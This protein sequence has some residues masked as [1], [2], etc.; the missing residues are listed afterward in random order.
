MK[1]KTLNRLVLFTSIVLLVVLA[2]IFCKDLFFQKDTDNKLEN[3][4]VIEFVEGQEVAQIDPEA[5]SFYLSSLD[6]RTKSH[7]ILVAIIGVFFTF[8]AFYVQ[9]SFNAT[10]REDISKE[11][12]ENGYSHHL[13]VFRGIWKDLMI[14]NVGDRKI[15]LHYMF[16]EYKAIYN[17]LIN[18]SVLENN[19]DFNRI[20]K[21]AFSLFLN[22]V[23]DNLGSDIEICK[24]S[25]GEKKRITKLCEKLMQFRKDSEQGND[26]GVTYIM[27]YKGKRIKYFDGHRMR[28]IPYF[29]Y[30]TGIFDYIRDN[31]KYSCNRDAALK[32]LFSEM[33]DHEFGLIYS[34]LRFRS[35]KEYDDYINL[36]KSTMDG[37]YSFK[38]LYDS[39]RFIRK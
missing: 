3:L 36:M 22:G 11:R 38:F 13:D 9:Y 37:E 10:Q 39:P 12:F 30:L 14:P 2:V 32:Q 17:L 7:D 24:L 4:K 28:L 34:F 25:N 19:S 27:D 33:S 29:K 23:S 26:S 6:H 31:E 8:I 16:Y 5:L 35:T 18:N 1:P 15:A 21:V 20:N